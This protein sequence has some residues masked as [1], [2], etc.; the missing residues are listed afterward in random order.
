MARNFDY[1]KRDFAQLRDEQFRYI[2]RYY[3]DIAQNFQD[4]SILSLLID[5]NAG[6]ADQLH[7]HIDRSL[8]ETVLDFAQQRG[9]L[10]NIAKTYGLKIPTRSASVCVA[11]FSIEVP[12][13][14][15][16]EDTRYTPILK[17]GSSFTGNDFTFELLSDI[18][19]RS[20]FNI[21]G[22]VD[23]TK[24]P[25]FNGNTIQSYTITKQGIL[26]NGETKV[27]SQSVLD[28]D[29]EPFFSITLP[30]T[31]V[32]SVDSVILKDGLNF[33]S[34]PSRQ[35]FNNSE[36]KWYEVNSLAEDKVFVENSNS[37]SNSSV[38]EGKYIKTENRFIK[39]FTPE[40]FCV[41]TFGSK[42]NESEDILE[43]FVRNGTID[44]RNFIDNVSLGK[45]PP[46]NST[47]FVKYRIGGGQDSNVRKNV[48]NNVDNAILAMDGPDEEIKEEVRGSLEVA[49][50]TPA[51]GGKDQP[52]LEE[53]RNYISYNFSSQNRA[54]TL[55]DYKVIAQSMPSKFGSPT[56]LSVSENQNKVQIKILTKDANGKLNNL[57]SSTIQ[58]NLANYISR[59]RNINDYVEIGPGQIVDFSISI[60]VTISPENQTEI[61][62][63]IISSVQNELV[64]DKREMGD[65]IFLGNVNKVISNID[66]VLNIRDVRYF[67]KVGGDYSENEISQPYL[68]PST[69]EIDTSDGVL[70]ADSNEILQLKFPERD[71]IVNPKLG[72]TERQS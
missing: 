72:Q 41:L 31:N 63:E 54:V 42:T 68:N 22:E 16:S 33:N 71:I 29:V 21:E 44:L 46:A 25:N 59:Y 43:D 65:D 53:L 2:Q 36:L 19:F 30:E 67:N 47:I 11:E 69:R 62:S 35:E 34:N 57:V 26:V 7:Y 60:D 15:D 4:G 27:F 5:L 1:A 50:I 37:N 23:R 38:K 58:N 12:P 10:Y 64:T 3:P 20:S 14:G 52:T 8:Q 49:N 51:V 18:D 56:K 32:L 61:V 17:A 66:G 48:I 24:I 6:I 9:S 40:N 45:T 55:D 39:E 28:A 13:R 70:F